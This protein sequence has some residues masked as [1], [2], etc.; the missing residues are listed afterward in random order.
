MLLNQNKKAM[1]I[2]IG[3]ILL[4]SII[5]IMS[6]FIYTWLKSYVPQEEIACPDG[7]SVFIKESRCYNDDGLK[8][9]LTLKNNGR[10]NIDGFFVH[11]TT[12][13]NQEL[14]IK[15][16]SGFIF[17]GNIEELGNSVRIKGDK[18]L[19][20]GKE[21]SAVFN[22][23]EQIYSI[24]ITPSRFQI[25]NNKNKFVSCVNAKIKEQISCD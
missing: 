25:Q 19:E 21:I 2:M 23:D 17:E 18:S 4:V 15:D 3:Y 1:S 13:P 7:V 14:A 5:L 6:T 22:L 11:A 20:S 24:E 16:L 12:S 10:F 8:L 9:N